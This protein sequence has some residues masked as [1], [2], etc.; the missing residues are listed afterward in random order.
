MPYRRTSTH[1]H[2]QDHQDDLRHHKLQKQTAMDCSP[3][4]AQCREDSSSCT[5]RV[6]V[7]VEMHVLADDFRV[8]VTS[9]AQQ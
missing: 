6:S 8:V 9:T 2:D 4:Q 3:Q 7:A 1:H 5:D